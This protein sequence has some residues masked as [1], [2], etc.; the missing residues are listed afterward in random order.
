LLA[1]DIIG[2]IEIACDSSLNPMKLSF[3]LSLEAEK[4]GAVIFDYTNVTGIRL[5]KKGAVES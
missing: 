5:D 4:N 3:G 1:D 2:G